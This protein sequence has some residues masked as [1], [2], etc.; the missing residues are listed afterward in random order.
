MFIDVCEYNNDTR[1]C[2]ILLI[3]F[4]LV[5]IGMDGEKRGK[6]KSRADMRTVNPVG[7]YCAV[8]CLSWIG[9]LEYRA[10]KT[11]L[12]LLLLS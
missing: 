1:H 7:W 4:I 6:K 9:F 12:L 8:A 5:I 2:T 3:L 10:D 11:L